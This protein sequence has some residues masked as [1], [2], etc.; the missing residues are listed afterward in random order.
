VVSIL[1]AAAGRQSPPEF[2]VSVKS[3]TVQVLGMPRTSVRRTRRIDVAYHYR[4]WLANFE[5]GFLAALRE[6]RDAPSAVPKGG[7]GAGTFFLTGQACFVKLAAWG[8]RI[9]PAEEPKKV[10]DTFSSRFLGP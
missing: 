1:L 9:A 8:D 4:D 6:K 10:P 5:W 2:T 3:R 7:G